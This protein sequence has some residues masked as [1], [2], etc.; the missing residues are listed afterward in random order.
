MYILLFVVGLALGS[1]LNA[2]VWRLHEHRN[3]VTERSECEYCHRRLSAADLIPVVSWLMI[4]GR[5]RYCHHKIGLQHVVVELL[6]G[7]LFA[8]SWFAWPGGH[9]VGA[10]FVVQFV[11]WLAL[12]VG[13]LILGLYDLKW[14]LLPDVVVF[15]LIALTIMDR[16]VNYTLFHADTG[17]LVSASLG[18][19]VV[20]GFFGLLY[21]VSKGRW[22]GLGDVKLGIL[23]G[24]VLG[25]SQ[26]LIAV[27]LSYYIGAIAV[28]PLLL[29]H[30]LK[31]KSVVAF[32]PFLI[33][34]FV[35]TF[36]YGHHLAMWY[37]AIMH[38]QSLNL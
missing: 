23:L 36:L 2:V 29:S 25:P 28:I 37:Q 32:G 17:S 31:A 5:C 26:G 11:F 21:A 35:V 33:I 20:S 18:A 8:L 1:F 4:R 38:G 22:I 24:L 27:V 9:G 34:S 3:F 6:T 10:H 19:V 7:V 14:Q 13:A 16:L 12:L 30:R 15:P